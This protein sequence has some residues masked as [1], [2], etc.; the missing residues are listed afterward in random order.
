MYR[1]ATMHESQTDGQ[2][3]GNTDDNTMPT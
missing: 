1:L 2:I 3:D